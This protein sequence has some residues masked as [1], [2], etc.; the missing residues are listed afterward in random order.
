MRGTFRWRRKKSL[1]LIVFPLLPY[2][3]FFG[4]RRVEREMTF[5]P[6]PYG[7]GQYWSPPVGAEDVGLFTSDNVR[8]HGWFIHSRIRPALA[9]VVYF[10]GNSGNIGNLGWLGEDLATRGFDALLFDYRGYGRSEGEIREERDLYADADAAYD[11]VTRERNVSP[12]DIALYGQSLGTAAVAD[13]ASRRGCGAIILESGLTSAGE[14]AEV[15]APLL[16]RWLGWIR[17]NHFESRQKLSAIHCPVLVTHG[18]PDDT[19]PTS[20][21]LALYA[22]APEPKKL[23]LVPGAGHNVC[24]SGG[25]GYFDD[26]SSFIREA[27]VGSTWRVLTTARGASPK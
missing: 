10:H 16:S 21:G 14:M 8:L 26:I 2:L 7:P 23:I 20:Q 15:K 13:L 18:Y 6:R 22:A 11:Y 3:F 1:S 24:G 19:I 12:A 9:T 17:R 27:I 25:E 4:L 5:N